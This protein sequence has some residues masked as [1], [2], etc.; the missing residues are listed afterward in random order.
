V[1]LRVLVA[2]AAVVGVVGAAFMRVWDQEA[3]YRVAD[4]LRAR[5]SDQW[6]NEERLAEVEAD[7]DEARELR[8]K[9]DA[10]LRAKRVELAGLRGEHAALLRRYAT[11]ETE[12]ASALEGRRQLALEAAAEP[13]ALPPAGSTPG[14]SAYLRAARA[15][16]DLTFNAEAQQIQRTLEAARLSEEEARTTDAEQPAGAGAPAQAGQSAEHSGKSAEHSGQP[17]E[18][19]EQPA[20]AEPAEH[21]AVAEERQDSGPRTTPP[22]VGEQHSRPSTALPARRVPGASAIVPYSPLRAPGRR[23]GTG[24]DFFGTQA[25]A[26]HVTRPRT[27]RAD[28][29]GPAATE[30]TP[31]AGSGAE[32]E[33]LADVVGEETFA[34]PRRTEERVVGQVID[35]TEHDETEPLDIGHLRSAIGT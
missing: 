18:P 17:G 31:S 12:R 24:F 8:V 15:L 11:A 34:A 23:P 3:G 22:V 2:A 25:P 30:K 13:K 20:P 5:E 35:L 7:I 19:A 32:G 14:A 9:L 27:A 21:T 16:D 10:K 1:V 4:L 28:A 33:D 29:A 26:P 6:K